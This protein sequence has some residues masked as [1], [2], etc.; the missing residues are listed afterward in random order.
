M[1]QTLERVQLRRNIKKNLQ[2]LYIKSSKDG[3]V[4]PLS[5]AVY[6]VFERSGDSNEDGMFCTM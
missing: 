6:P 3:R 5:K 1:E 2:L 4:S